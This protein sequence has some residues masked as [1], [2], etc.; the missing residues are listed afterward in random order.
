MAVAAEARQVQE[1]RG[2][3]TE[4]TPEP[5][6]PCF[7]CCS[8]YSDCTA[9]MKHSKLDH[10]YDHNRR[11]RRGEAHAGGLS[12]RAHAGGQVRGRQLTSTADLRLDEPPRPSVSS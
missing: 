12:E 9:L 10:V 8:V 5:P 11:Q 3:L 4:L 1:G 7:S 2:R 6:F